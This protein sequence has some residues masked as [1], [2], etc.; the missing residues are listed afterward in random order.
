MIEYIK[1]IPRKAWWLIGWSALYA[2]IALGYMIYEIQTDVFF[3]DKSQFR[4]VLM[5]V[6]MPWL[7]I[8]GAP[9]W[10]GTRLNRWV[11]ASKKE[12]PYHVI[13]E[14]SRQMYVIGI[15]GTSV[16][17]SSGYKDAIRYRTSQEANSVRD[18]L[19]TNA[20][21]G[22]QYAV[23]VVFRITARKPE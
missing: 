20:G 7:I 1:S 14:Q 6:Q 9:L 10:P 18:M 8:M 16:T 17:L 2:M 23:E 22:Q 12:H 5:L 19:Q 11:F 4:G 21:P 15:I 13:I 3:T